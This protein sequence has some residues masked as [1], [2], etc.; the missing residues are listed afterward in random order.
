MMPSHFHGSSESIFNCKNTNNN[1]RN[2]NIYS[3]QTS[4][5][6]KFLKH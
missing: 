2:S 4:A 1:E 6:T 5:L 3:K